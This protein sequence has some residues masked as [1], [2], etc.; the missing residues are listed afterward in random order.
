MENIGKNIFKISIQDPAAQPVNVM[1]AW[2]TSN[3]TFL[4]ATQLLSSWELLHRRQDDVWL[5]Q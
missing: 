2:E 1:Q 4:E 5:E 3:K